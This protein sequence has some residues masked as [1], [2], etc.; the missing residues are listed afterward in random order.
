VDGWTMKVG[1]MMMVWF[2]LVWLL[3]ICQQSLWIQ[4]P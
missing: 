4:P 3:P 1:G 2:G